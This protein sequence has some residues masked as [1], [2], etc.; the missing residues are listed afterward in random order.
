MVRVVSEQSKQTYVKSQIDLIVVFYFKDPQKDI[1]P[2]SESW[3][4]SIINV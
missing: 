3:M 4:V 2:Q 1:K